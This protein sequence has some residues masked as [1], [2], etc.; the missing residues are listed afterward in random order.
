MSMRLQ[1]YCLLLLFL[2]PVDSGS[3]VS[4]YF[5]TSPW[6]SSAGHYLGLHGGVE[7]CLNLDLPSV[8]IEN[9]VTKGPFQILGYDTPIKIAGPKLKAEVAKC[10]LRKESPPVLSEKKS[11]ILSSKFMQ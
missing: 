6:N 7:F 8:R 5:T 9:L 4:L 3:W 2:F 11:R 1:C 10:D